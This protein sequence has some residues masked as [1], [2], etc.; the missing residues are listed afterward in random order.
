MKCLYF[1]PFLQAQCRVTP[2]EQVD[3]KD[4]KQS[5]RNI[6]GKREIWMTVGEKNF[7]QKSFI[8]QFVTERL[9]LPLA[10]LGFV[11]VYI[12]TAILLCS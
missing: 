3:V 1:N 6:E 7:N 12:A 2:V 4:E 5:E 10:A 9:W 11:L 8:N